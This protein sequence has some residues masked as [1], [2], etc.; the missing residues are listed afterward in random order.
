MALRE[1]Y[2][3]QLDKAAFLTA[4]I[5]LNLAIYKEWL[6]SISVRAADIAKELLLN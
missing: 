4:F 3:L 1:G 6:L 5:S 2:P